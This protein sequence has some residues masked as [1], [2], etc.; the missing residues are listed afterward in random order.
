M[1]TYTLIFI[2]LFLS[3][4]SKQVIVKFENRP[5]DVH[6]AEPLT[7][8]MLINKSSKIVLRTPEAKKKTAAWEGASNNFLNRRSQDKDLPTASQEHLFPRYD[9]DLLYSAIEKQ[10]FLEGFKVRDRSLFNEVISKAEKTDYEKLS[11]LTD[12]DLILEIIDINPAIPYQIDVC[13][14]QKKNR[15]KTI[16]LY[17][18]KTLYGASVE[19]KLIHIKLNEVVGTYKQY[20]VPCKQGCPYVYQKGHL[21]NTYNEDAPDPNSIITQDF[22]E[23]FLVDATRELVKVIR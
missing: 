2:I 5:I 8:L 22:L 11:S 4:C 14:P 9:T 19:F 17:E 16:R 23:R 20:Y 1:K 12:T 7:Q 6:T 15:Q 10:L 21:T 13:Y 18:K 3:G